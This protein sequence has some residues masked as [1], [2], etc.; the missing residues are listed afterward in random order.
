MISIRWPPWDNS[1]SVHF[2]SVQSVMSDSL[3]PHG[4]QNTRPLCPSPTPG[5]YSNPSPLSW[6]CHPTISSSVIPFPFSS[7]LQTFPASEP[8]QMSQFFTSGGQSLEVSASASILPMNIHFQWI[9]I[10]MKTMELKQSKENASKFAKLVYLEVINIFMKKSKE[11][12][13]TEL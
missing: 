13:W 2:I 10:Y 9:C 12:K 1:T 11:I 8:F 5:V 4:M 3:W 7:C 6:W